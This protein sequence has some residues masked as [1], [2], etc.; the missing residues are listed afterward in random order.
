MVVLHRVVQLVITREELV[1]RGQTI[2]RVVKQVDHPWV[3]TVRAHR[4]EHDLSCL[5]GHLLGEL[6]LRIQVRKKLL[7]GVRV[8]T[9]ATDVINLIAKGKI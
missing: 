2:V 5:I 9:L 6:H 1:G 8:L 4:V 7:L 3:S